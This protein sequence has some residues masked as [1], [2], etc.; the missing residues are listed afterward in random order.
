MVIVL[1][2]VWCCDESSVSTVCEDGL[3]HAHDSGAAGEWA[4]VSKV[5]SLVAD[6]R[7]HVTKVNVYLVASCVTVEVGPGT[8]RALRVETE[9][10]DVVALGS[11]G[12]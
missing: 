7:H 1:R 2:R 11:L 4:V 12:D 6:C 10:V 5:V 3:C 8:E 9:V